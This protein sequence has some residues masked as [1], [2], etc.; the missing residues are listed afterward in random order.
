MRV[1]VTGASGLVGSSV[2]PALVAAGHTVIAL[3][4]SE[5]SARGIVGASEIIIG[6]TTDTQIL[7]DAA[8][9]VDAVIHLA[10]PHDLAFQGKAVQACEDDRKAIQTM[11]DALVSSSEKDGG[12]RRFFI[13]TSGVMGLLGDDEKAQQSES[14]VMPRYLGDRLVASYGEKDLLHTH[15][16][17]LSPVS[18]GP[19]REHPFISTQIKVAKET[20]VAA[21]I[22]EGT[23]SWN[24][25]HVDDAAQIYVLALQGKAPNGQP[26]HAIAEEDIPFKDIAGFIGKRVGAKV[27][28]ISNQEGMKRYGFVG[29]AMS[30]G[31]RVTAKYTREW[32]GWK[33][34]KYGLFEEMENYTW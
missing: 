29:F 22:G 17:R 25:V 9:K 12:Q 10:F 19:K 21:Y 2:V 14:P 30:R 8:T 20:G 24:A 4:R 34:I 33:P 6:S 5:E 16:V 32:L 13:G 31:S 15:V 1:L 23:N 26:L 28:S 7:H 3:S 11:C 18:H 27:E